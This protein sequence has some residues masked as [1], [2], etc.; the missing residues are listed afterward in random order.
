MLAQQFKNQKSI[1]KY[2]SNSRQL[3]NDTS[4]AHGAVSA[5]A[6]GDGWELVESMRANQAQ[7]VAI[8][9]YFA[10]LIITNREIKMPDRGYDD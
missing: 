8:M 2:A 4:N 9:S 3:S 10:K 1:K 5:L 7:P 6:V